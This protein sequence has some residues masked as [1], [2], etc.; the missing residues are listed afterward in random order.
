[1]IS[2]API[3]EANW[4]AA[5]AVRVQPE[6]LQW[7]ASVEPVALIMLAKC[8]V[9]YD[10]QVWHPFVLMDD[11]R[12]VGIAAVGVNGQAA[13]VHHVLIDVDAQGRGLGRQLMLLIAAW[14]R[15]SHSSVD[16]VGLNVVPQNEVAWTLYRSLGFEPIG[17]TLDDQ[18]ITLARLEDVR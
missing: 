1:V 6:R 11:D 18:V 15:A 5:L 3:T 12:V 14:L 10:G 2:L 13:W 16:R 7:V 8:W 9:N 4:Q 17:R